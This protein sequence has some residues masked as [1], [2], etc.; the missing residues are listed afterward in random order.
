[1]SGVQEPEKMA[2]YVGHPLKKSYARTEIHRLI[3]IMM[4]VN[5]ASKTVIVLRWVCNV[6]VLGF[7]GKS[8]KKS[9]DIYH[10]IALNEPI[11][12]E[13]AFPTKK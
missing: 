13:W 8:C 5:T 12:Y 2:H 4:F 1:M 11:S 6:N 3:I 7:G 9:G 10:G